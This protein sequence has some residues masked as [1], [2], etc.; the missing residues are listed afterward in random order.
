MSPQQSTLADRLVSWFNPMAAVQRAHARRVLAYYEAAKSE[1]TRKGRR[2]AGSGNDA[3]LRAGFSGFI[4][5]RSARHGWAG[6]PRPQ[7]MVVPPTHRQ[8]RERP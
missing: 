6:S 3:V 7:T 4:V 8:K 5:R 2:E 1:R